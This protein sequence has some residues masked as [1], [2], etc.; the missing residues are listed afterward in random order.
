M[1]SPK[2]QALRDE[3][4]RNGY[5]TTETDRKIYNR[6]W[7]GPSINGPF[8]AQQLLHDCDLFAHRLANA[9]MAILSMRAL[10]PGDLPSEVLQLI[11]EAGVPKP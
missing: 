7:S 2:E 1:A 4:K 8:F 11:Q 9:H 10:I 3:A 5:Q 6:M